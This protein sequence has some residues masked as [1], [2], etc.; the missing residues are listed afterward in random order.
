MFFYRFCSELIAEC[1]VPPFTYLLMEMDVWIPLLVALGFQVIATVMTSLIPETL[2]VA[3]PEITTDSLNDS[4]TGSGSSSLYKTTSNRIRM[5]RVKDSF[6]FITRDRTVSALVFTFLISKF[7]RQSS[8][9]LFQYV[10]KRYHW[11]LSQVRAFSR[12]SH[13][14]PI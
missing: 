13:I 5:Q 9:V 11:N 3:S 7:G 4:T 14:S 12:V 2:P 10:S 6:A 1:F 8:T